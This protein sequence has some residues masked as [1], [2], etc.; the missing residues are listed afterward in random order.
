MTQHELLQRIKERLL[1]LYGKRFRGLV[2]YG[3]VARGEDGDDSDIDLLCLLDGPVNT[4]EEIHPIIKTTYPI[5]LE[6]ADRV[7]DITAV[8]IADFEEGAYPLCIEA[9]KEGIAV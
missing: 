7:F 3:S 6:Y 1:E 5:Q 2:L 8:D 9:R 4:I